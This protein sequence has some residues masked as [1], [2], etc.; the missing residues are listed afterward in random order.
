[1]L[2]K[3]K[4]ISPSEA[5]HIL[6]VYSRRNTHKPIRASYLVCR[7]TNTE[8][9]NVMVMTEEMLKK[10]DSKFIYCHIYSVMPIGPGRCSKPIPNDDSANSTMPKK[11]NQL[12]MTDFINVVNKEVEKIPRMVEFNQKMKQT[13]IEK[14][15][16]PI[17]KHIIVNDWETKL[18]NEFSQLED[19]LEFMRDEEGDLMIMNVEAPEV[20]LP[21]KMRDNCSKNEN[22][23]LMAEDA[24]MFEENKVFEVDVKEMPNRGDW[25]E[26]EEADLL[27][28]AELDQSEFKQTREVHDFVDASVQDL[29]Q[30]KEGD[31]FCSEAQ[32]GLEAKL[33]SQIFDSNAD[34]PMV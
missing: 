20:F 5:K 23:T 7:A 22:K 33:Q 12:L 32:E 15:T 6:D 11:E 1:M 21:L 31:I 13:S 16:L 18:N 30:D 17:K 9:L 25:L 3:I 26:D 24:E 2:S 14:F 4:K 8:Y 34:Q 27:C 28:L 19:N 10:L 29:M